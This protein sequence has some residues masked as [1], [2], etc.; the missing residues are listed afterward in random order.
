MEEKNQNNMANMVQ[1][2]DTRLDC[3]SIEIAK[4]SMSADIVIDITGISMRDFSPTMIYNVI[5]NS[6]LNEEMVNFS[7]IK[8]VVDEVTNRKKKVLPINQVQDPS[9]SIVRQ[10][11]ANGIQIV[12]GIDG[13]V[14]FYHPHNQRVVIKEDGS[15]DFRNLEKFISIKKAEKIAT[16]FAGVPGKPGKDVFGAVLNAP[17][18]KRPKIT[19]GA[20]II[21]TNNSSPEEPEKIY[22]EYT[23]ACDGVLFST[24]ESVTVSPELR[25]DQ[26]VGITTGNVKY[27]GTVNVMGSIEDGSRV[28]CEGSLNVGENLESS[29]ISVGKDLFV[30]GGIKAKAKGLVKIAGNVK[31]KFIENSILEVGGD[32]IIEGYILNSKIYCL[33]SI[34]LTG[35]TSAILGSDIV[36]MGGLSTYNLG[37]NAG[38]DVVVELGVHFQNERLFDEFQNK[39][40]ASEKEMTNII[41]QV[42]QA[43]NMIKQLRGKL[44]EDK[45]KKFTE[46]F[47][48][49]KQ[50]STNHKFVTEKFEELKT[51]RFNQEHINVVVKGA[52]YPG[53]VIK[54]RRQI[55]KLTAMQ[56]AF[57]MSFLPGQESAPM[58][59]ISVKKK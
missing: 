28:E 6:K 21:T 32:L 7:L 12:H 40:K 43:N 41:P 53:A 2:T 52:A 34:V 26:S 5:T 25:I 15:A 38:V 3:I 22:I 36:V 30:K 57:M 11:I 20:N 56:S 17:A 44:D 42:Q 10:Q 27:N 19:I 4:D 58:T 16:L 45:K 8:E 35:P 54:Y 37:S 49:F 31:A 47:E 46:L 24:D 48:Q 14:K 9:E 18:I 1:L 29:D 50:K 59:A 33:G 13:W 23:S 39:V 55:E 51:S